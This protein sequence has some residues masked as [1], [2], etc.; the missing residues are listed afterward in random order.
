MFRSTVLALVVASAS[1]VLA[2]S[3]VTEGQAAG[4]AGQVHLESTPGPGHPSADR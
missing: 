2:T 3:V 1:A 4:P